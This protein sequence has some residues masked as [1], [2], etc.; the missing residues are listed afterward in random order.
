V[1][2]RIVSPDDVGMSF[3]RAYE[4]IFEEEEDDG[5]TTRIRPEVCTDRYVLSFLCTCTAISILCW[6]ASLLH[7]STEILAFSTLKSHFTLCYFLENVFHL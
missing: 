1:S 5:Q 4:V 6:F 7:P 3:E 2:I